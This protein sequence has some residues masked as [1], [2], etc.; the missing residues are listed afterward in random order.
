MTMKIDHTLTTTPTDSVDGLNFEGQE[1]VKVSYKTQLLRVEEDEAPE[2][3]PVV[4]V[5]GKTFDIYTMEKV[6]STLKFIKSN[7]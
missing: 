3:V 6:L 1:D 7:I 2:E 5:E 4:T